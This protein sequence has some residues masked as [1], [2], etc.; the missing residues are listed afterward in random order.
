M[1]IVVLTKPVPDP[2]AAE[3]LGADGRVDRTAG[4][5]INGND[6]YALEAALVVLVV[7]FTPAVQAVSHISTLAVAALDKVTVSLPVV[8]VAVPRETGSPDFAT[9]R[10]SPAAIAVAATLA[11]VFFLLA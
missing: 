9:R 5:V 11:K 6:E 4:N 8:Q 3:H 10:V 2:T 1:R 7:T